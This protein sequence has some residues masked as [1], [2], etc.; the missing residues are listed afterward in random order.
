MKGS[1]EMKV[2]GLTGGIASGKSTVSQILKQKGIPIIDADVIAREI[3]EIG[4]PA[5]QEI[6]DA[7]GQKVINQDGSLNRGALAKIVFFNKEKLEKLNNIM[8]KRII[9]K[10]SNTIEV[11]RKKTVHPM[12]VVDAA[13][14]IELNMIA[15][16]DEVWLIAVNKDIQLA[17]LIKR[18][19]LSTEEAIHRMN[20]QMSIEEKKEH[21]DIIIDNN[22]DLDDLRKQI[23]KQLYRLGS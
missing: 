20:T 23:E 4:Q 8:H 13:L 18:E 9:E 14:L 12:I 3:V 10:I 15:L 22:R 19:S 11:Y 1:I 5:L 17:R 7:F 2:I 16:V 6:K 21:A